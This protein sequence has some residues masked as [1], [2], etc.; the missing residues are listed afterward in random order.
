M[1]S[2]P[3]RRLRL[4]TL[5]LALWGALTSLAGAQE[6][7]LELT[8][9]SPPPAAPEAVKVDSVSNWRL[10]LLPFALRKPFSKPLVEGGSAYVTPAHVLT[11]ADIDTALDEPGDVVPISKKEY[12][13]LNVDTATVERLGTDYLKAL[14]IKQPV[15]YFRDRKGLVEYAAI[16]GADPCIASLMLLPDFYTRFEPVFGTG[17]RVVAPDQFTLYLFPAE[18]DTINEFTRPLADQFH[19]SPH[20]VS[21][22]IYQFTEKGIGIVAELPR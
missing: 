1:F 4:I 6:N 8:T 10:V 18:G 3:A 20:P 22:E 5:S 7:A 15:Q 16:N 21:L 17:F 19:D 13:S 14:L 12:D 11:A 2:K 9:S